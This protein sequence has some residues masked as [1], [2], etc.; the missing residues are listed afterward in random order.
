MEATIQLLRKHGRRLRRR[1]LPAAKPLTG[2]LTMFSVQHRAYG[3]VSILQLTAV[4]N[5][6]ADGHL[7]TLYEPVLT[8]LGNGILTF[9]GIER[10]QTPDGPAGYAQEW[11]CTVAR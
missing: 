3:S 6:T 8:G 10:V 11:R 4:A 1:D 2:Q 5:Q 9:R 7:A